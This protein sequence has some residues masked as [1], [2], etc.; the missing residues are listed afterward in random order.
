MRKA[1]YLTHRDESLF[2]F[3]I[4]QTESLKKD[5]EIF[6]LIDVKHFLIYRKKDDHS[7]HLYSYFLRKN[8]KEFDDIIFKGKTEKFHKLF[9]PFNEE[10]H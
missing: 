10:N 2:L 7:D 4:N 9:G 6:L 5:R 8:N 1:I 3:I